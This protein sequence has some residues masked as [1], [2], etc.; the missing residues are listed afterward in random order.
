MAELANAITVHP[1]DSGLKLD[2]QKIVL[3]IFVSQLNLNMLG[4]N[5]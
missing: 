1:R 3:I 4:V 5:S 2:R